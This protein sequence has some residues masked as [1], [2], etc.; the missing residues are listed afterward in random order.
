MNYFKKKNFTEWP[1]LMAISWQSFLELSFWHIIL[2]FGINPFYTY[3]N[4]VLI[5]TCWNSIE[6]AK[7]LG[8][9][10]CT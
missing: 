9:L 4:N 1:N 6:K 5:P 7:I 2:K 8:S 10:E 3:V